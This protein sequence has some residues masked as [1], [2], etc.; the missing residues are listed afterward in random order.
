MVPD[1]AQTRPSH[2]RQALRRKFSESAIHHNL[3]PV[4]VSHEFHAPIIRSGKPSFQPAI[5]LI[6]RMDPHLFARV[7]RFVAMCFMTAK[8]F[9]AP[10]LRTRLS[11]SRKVTAG[12]R[13]SRFPGA[14]APHARTARRRAAATG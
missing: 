8:P 13:C 1:L 11:S 7:G 2:F 6:T 14:G 10:S 12:T 9:G 4:G 5:F 3:H